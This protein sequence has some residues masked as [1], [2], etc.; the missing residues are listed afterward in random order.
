M[1]LLQRQRHLAMVVVFLAFMSGCATDSAFKKKQAQEARAM[2]ERFLGA[3]KPS[4]ALQQFLRAL[5]YDPDDPYLHYDTALAYDMLVLDEQP[6]PP[7][8]EFHL[9]E[10]IR[11]KPDYSDAYNY[12]GVVYIRKGK[13]DEA[14][15]MYQKAL[16]NE[17]YLK[18]Q[19]AHLNL[20]VAYLRRNEYGKAAKH[21][22]SAIRLIPDYVDAYYN[23]GKAYEG[24]RKYREARRSYEKAIEFRPNYAGAHLNLGRLLY[25]SGK[26][27]EA[28]R[29]FK[30]VIRLAPDSDEAREAQSYLGRLR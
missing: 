23:L 24:L 1:N 30:E 25:R 20:G 3:N 18:K 4:V 11:L 9:G 16:S 7:K 5:E 26:T 22:E 12:L 17:L 15:A 8:T 29:S 21:L 14:I 13:V 27:G 2:G 19:E 28:A 10:A 6:A